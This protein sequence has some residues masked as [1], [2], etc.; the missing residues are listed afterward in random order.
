MQIH[1]PTASMLT[2]CIQLTLLPVENVVLSFH[3]HLIIPLN[4]ATFLKRIVVATLLVSVHLKTHDYP[5][6]LSELL[7]SMATARQKQ[8]TVY[9]N[10]ILGTL[11]PT[12]SAPSFKPVNVFHSLVLI[13]VLINLSLRNPKIYIQRCRKLAV[14]KV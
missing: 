2:V 1:V 10:I 8:C 12:K 13:R 3:A 4:T 14:V 11:S 7:S 9:V 5:K 6:P